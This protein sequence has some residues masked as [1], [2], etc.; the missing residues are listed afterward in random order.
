MTPKAKADAAQRLL[1]DE[2]LQ[3]ALD[4]IKQEAIGVFTYPTSSQEDIMEAHRMIR[5]QERLESNLKKFITNFAMLDR[6]K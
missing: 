2:T 4:M 5:A 3:E 6:R 1:S